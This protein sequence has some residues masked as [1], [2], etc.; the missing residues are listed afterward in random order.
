M[1]LK[2]RFDQ[3][4]PLE[5]VESN[6]LLPENNPKFNSL[7]DED[8]AKYYQEKRAQIKICFENLDLQSY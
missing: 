3:L 5:K 8:F 6:W 2:T 7:N 4:K 1:D